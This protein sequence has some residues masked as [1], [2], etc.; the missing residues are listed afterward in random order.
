MA[1]LRTLG[2]MLGNL[3]LL[4]ILFPISWFRRTAPARTR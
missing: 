3:I 1:F 4:L 2:G